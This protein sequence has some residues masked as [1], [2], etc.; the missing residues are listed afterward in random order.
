MLNGAAAKEPVKSVSTLNGAAKEP[1]K[2]GDDNGATSKDKQRRLTFDDEQHEP[3][4][5]FFHP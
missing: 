2:S 1:V 5:I 3:K 4:G